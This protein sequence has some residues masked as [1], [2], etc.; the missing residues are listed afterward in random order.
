MCAAVAL[1]A[2]QRADAEAEAEDADPPSTARASS[3]ERISKSVTVML[4]LEETDVKRDAG[5]QQAM[6][7]IESAC[8][9]LGEALL[10]LETRLVI[11]YRMVNPDVRDLL[12]P[13]LGRIDGLKSLRVL[14]AGAQAIF[15]MISDFRITLA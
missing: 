5:W 9:D 4:G 6:P 15:A 3:F 7:A 11:E 13:W 10:H 1:H 12:P 8:E 14:A 2:Q